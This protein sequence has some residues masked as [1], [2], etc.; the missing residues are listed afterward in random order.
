[1]RLNDLAEEAATEATTFKLKAQLLEQG[2]TDEEIVRTDNM[3]ARLKVYASGGENVL[4]AHP[5]EDHMFLILQGRATFYDKDGTATELG[6]YEGILLPARAYY[7]FC[8]TGDEPLVLFRI[9]AKAG[10]P[11]ERKAGITRVDVTGAPIH[12]ESEAN[13]E[14]PVVFREGAYFG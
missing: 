8:A 5:I 6:K 14:V 11:H 9:G 13:K 10:E 3:W 7:W 4:H 1:M 2:R 12:G